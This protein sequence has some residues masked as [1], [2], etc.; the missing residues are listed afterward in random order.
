MVTGG[1]REWFFCWHHSYVI[2]SSRICQGVGWTD[3]HLLLTWWL[4]GSSTRGHVTYMAS[5]PLEILSGGG[6]FVL[7]L[8]ILF[9]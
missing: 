9:V 3:I 4:S 8:V 5:H 6:C 2:P 1:F 7:L